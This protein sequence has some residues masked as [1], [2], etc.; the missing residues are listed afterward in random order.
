MSCAVMSYE[1]CVGSFEHKSNV[2][3]PAKHSNGAG[4]KQ[5]SGRNDT[6]KANNSNAKANLFAPNAAT[7]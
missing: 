1:S 7:Y 4:S 5:L 3:P 6:I 2:A